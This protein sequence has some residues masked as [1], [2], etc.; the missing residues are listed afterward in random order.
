MPSLSE[1]LAA[2]ENPATNKDNRFFTDYK[3]LKTVTD[4]LKVAG[5]KVVLT[6]GVFD[7]LHVGHAQ[8]L[9][10]AREHGDVLVV[11]VDSDELTRKRKGEGRPIVPEDERVNILL[12]LRHVDM[13]V[14]RN[15]QSPLEE[16]IETIHPDVLV[17]SH[18]TDDMPRDNRFDE[19]CGEIITL[20][21]QSVTSTT[22]RI[23][24]VSMVG[25]DQL[26]DELSRQIP[27][28]VRSMLEKLKSK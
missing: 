22:A 24:T 1:R 10:K 8:Y 2:L 23:R 11:G 3:D 20:A 6:Q 25:A 18:S 13:V 21:P 7:L 19:H 12:H 16:L 5:K 26:A 4:A 17:V 28:L 9:E 14:L 27:D 15:A